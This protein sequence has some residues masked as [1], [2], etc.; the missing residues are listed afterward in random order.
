MAGRLTL[1]KEERLVR[2]KDI[3]T[4]F[5]TGKAFSVFPLRVIYRLVPLPGGEHFNVRAGF[6]AAKKKFKRAVDRNRIKRLMRES[7]R[8]QK[9][10]LSDL[11]PEGQQLQLFL[12]FTDKEL[13]IYEAVF[14]AAGKIIAKL[15]ASLQSASFPPPA[16]AGG[17]T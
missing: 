2:E 8:L 12:L 5:R 1:G 9:A 7:W 6:S 13:P 10:A 14:T 17:G 3:E 15:E 4:L 11:V 16:P